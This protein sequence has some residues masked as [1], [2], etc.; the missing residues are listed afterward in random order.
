MSFALGI[1]QIVVAS[2]LLIFSG[3]RLAT[4]EL[5]HAFDV[6]T[7]F[8]L[9]DLAPV[10]GSFTLI[11]VGVATLRRKRWAFPLGVFGCVVWVII[12]ILNLVDSFD[13]PPTLVPGLPTRMAIGAL[14]PP[15]VFL[16]AYALP[17]VRADFRPRPMTRADYLKLKK[18]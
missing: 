2:G 15:I 14:L 5:L 9:A 11:A 18:S 4:H 12:A 17:S 16:A 7:G 13:A 10:F 1:V 6:T 3:A 8:T